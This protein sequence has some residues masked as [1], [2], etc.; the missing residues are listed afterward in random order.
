MKEGLQLPGVANDEDPDLGFP[1][2][3]TQ[4]SLLPEEDLTVTA[5]AQG[6][7]THLASQGN[8]EADYE[9]GNPEA[10]YEEGNPEADYED[11]EAGTGTSQ[12]SLGS[13]NLRYHLCPNL[14]VSSRFKELTLK[15]TAMTPSHLS[16]FW[17]VTFLLSVSF[18][19][20]QFGV[21]AMFF[22]I[23]V[24]EECYVV[25]SGALHFPR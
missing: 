17:F 16:V 18:L 13:R 11:V 9:E 20:C 24:W 21:S 2:A 1:E 23:L 15:E 7:R 25:G 4:S 12:E 10:D 5:G 6:Q 14:A 3:M 22:D 19:M 8:P